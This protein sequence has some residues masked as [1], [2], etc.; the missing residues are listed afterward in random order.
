[1]L[2]S[3]FL[4]FR[5][6]DPR[7]NKRN[8]HNRIIG[9]SNFQKSLND[10]FSAGGFYFKGKVIEGSHKEKNTCFKSWELLL[11]MCIFEIATFFSCLVVIQSSQF[12][13]DGTYL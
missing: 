7:I 8:I 13:S 12:F 6:F 4:Y 5:F 1:M 2:H 3:F 11:K 9:I 10:P